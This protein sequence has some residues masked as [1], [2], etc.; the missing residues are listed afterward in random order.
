LKRLPLTVL[1]VLMA[2][3][4]VRLGFWQLDRRAQRQ[5][6]N[7]MVSERLA[8]PPLQLSGSID[9]PSEL[10]FRHAIASGTFDYDNEL[11]LQRSSPS[12]AQGVQILTPLR[13][14]GSD[15]AVLVDRGWIP[16]EQ[17]PLDQRR[18]FQ[19]EPAAR[20]Q[21]LVRV[22]ASGRSVAPMSQPAGRNGEVVETWFRVDLPR[23]QQVLPYR[24]LP[25]YLEQSPAADGPALPVRSENIVWHND[26]Q[27]L[28]Y[29]AQWFTFAVMLIGGYVAVFGW[30]PKER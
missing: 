14:A 17:S 13:I 27:N 3:V 11:L 22:P 4:L 25:I 10:A 8:L 30:R 19:G 29:A 9:N 12:G 2:L 18:Q 5:A 24:L 26:V 7:A 23:M 28:G 15:A 1:V 20:V 6:L 21:G 16:F